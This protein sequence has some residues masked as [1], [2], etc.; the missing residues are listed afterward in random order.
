MSETQTA[1]ATPAEEK[2]AKIVKQPRTCYCQAFEVY[3]ETEDETFT[4]GCTQ[5]T[6]STFAQGHDAQLVSFLVSSYFDGYK[7]RQATEQGMVNHD[8][9]ESAARTASEALGNKA[10]YA[11][12]N[13]KARLDAKTAREAEKEKKKAERKAEAERKAAEKAAAAEAKKAQPKATGAEVVSTEGQG[14]PLAEGES[15]IKV[16]KFEYN[17][18]IDEDGNAAYVDGKGEQQLVERDG[19]RLLQEAGTAN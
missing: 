14:L 18:V 19:Y 3:G 1:E 15:R 4:T 13:A 17:A 2:P 16:G 12:E 11:T 8:T 7:I 5:T 9:P 6:K 10:K